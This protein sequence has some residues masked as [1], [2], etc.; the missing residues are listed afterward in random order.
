MVASPIVAPRHK[1]SGLWQSP[2]SI[3]RPNLA[4]QRALQPST[5]RLSCPRVRARR[6]MC[7]AVGDG[8]MENAAAARDA[9]GGRD[10]LAY[11]LSANKE[12][13][14]LA[15]NAT[16][17]VREAQR[18]HNLAPTPSAA[19]GRLLMAASLLAAMGRKRRETV[20]ITFK[21]TGP[22]GTMTA[23]ADDEG[24]VK[25]VVNNPNADM[26]LRADGKLNVGGIV[27]KGVIAVVRSAPEWKQPFTGM[28]P[29]SS[30]EVGE[31]IAVYLAES[32]QINSAVGLGVSLAPESRVIEAAGA[33]LI[34][35]LPGISEESLQQLEAT[36]STLPSPSTLIKQGLTSTQIAEKILERVGVAPPDGDGSP[37]IYP[38]YGP[39]EV[40]QLEE[41]MRRSLALL[42]KEELEKLMQEQ[43][44]LEM[45]CEFCRHSAQF[46]LDDLKAVLEQAV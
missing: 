35:V 7:S 38:T 27:G 1:L 20:Q 45:T 12:L 22:V 29:I 6:V 24:R 10:E 18:R 15:L 11:R 3:R 13:S 41:R 8:S 30:G 2:S 16:N 32:E 17:L 39:C 9:P 14:V 28:V 43:G 21:G 31:D 34:Q 19:L 4:C 23:I 37:V 25:G 5:G 36:L 42:G 26:P 44:H 46:G 40:A 33:Y